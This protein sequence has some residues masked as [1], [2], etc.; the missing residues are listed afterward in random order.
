MQVRT[1]TWRISQE[2]GLFCLS[3][4]GQK[5]K[6]YRLYSEALATVKRFYRR[7]HTDAVRPV[8]KAREE[9]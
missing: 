7:F 8:S 1:W 6:F 2:H 3:I 9:W 5:A 4:S